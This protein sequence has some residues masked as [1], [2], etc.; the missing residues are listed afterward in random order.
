[1]YEIKG[2]KVVNNYYKSTK[3]DQSFQIRLHRGD[4]S[5]GG[6][7]GMF[8]YGLSKD[9]VVANVW[10]YDTNWK[11]Q[12]YEDGVFSGDMTLSYADYFNTDAWSQAYHIGVVNRNPTNYSQKS[13]HDFVHK[14]KNPN[15]KVR[16]VAIDNYGNQY[17]QTTF[18][19]DLESAH[20]YK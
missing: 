16:V 4:G 9:F 2:T 8:G 18:T 17:E 19:E 14:L 3:Y 7:H 13:T 20:V 1:M 12:V 11:I 10:N 6:E 5:W 15:A